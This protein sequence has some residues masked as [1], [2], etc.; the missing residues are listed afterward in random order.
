MPEVRSIPRYARRYFAGNLLY[1]LPGIAA[2][3]IMWREFPRPE[4][5]CECELTLKFWIG[6]SVFVAMTLIGG[7]VEVLRYKRFRCPQCRGI[8]PQ[9]PAQEDQNVRYYCSVCD[10]VWDTGL[11]RGEG[12]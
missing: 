3:Y 1:V 5:G 10:I 4:H 9:Q 11:V 12:T 8:I 7:I 6:L 2:F